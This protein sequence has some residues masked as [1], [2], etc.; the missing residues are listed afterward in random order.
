[1]KK[2]NMVAVRGFR[3]TEA[4]RRAGRLLRAPD[5]HPDGAPQ[6]QG[7]GEGEGEGGKPKEEPKPQGQQTP[8]DGGG[9]NEE[10]ER[11]R[12][13]LAE[14]HQTVA[15][16]D[17]IDPE[18]AR[19]NA[20]KLEE[21]AAAARAAEEAQARAEGNFGRLR[22]LQNEEF[23]A[24]LAAITAERDAARTEAETLRTA[25]EK[26]NVSKTFATSEFF[27]KET[28]L[29][30]AKAERLYGDFVELEDGKVVVYDAPRGE[31]KRAKVMDSRGNP[32]PFDQAIKK[33]VDAEPDKDTILKSKMNPGGGS[34]TT[35]GKPGGNQQ[36]DRL[37]KLSAGLAAL[38][39]GR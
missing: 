28:I 4:E 16:Y 32:L 23:E 37:S 34:K 10:L 33:V 2:S 27:S 29:S 14:A 20:R 31:A 9:S 38:R 30:P 17:G 24:R 12:R 6:G 39:G 25:A 21:A 5:G 35:E 11:L 3:M 13:E 7:Q 36:P 18:V 15:K 26:A 1:M 19:E 8:N 22:E